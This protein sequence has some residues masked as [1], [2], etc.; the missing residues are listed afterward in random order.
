MRAEADSNTVD[1]VLDKSLDA[2]KNKTGD[3]VSATLSADM[4]SGNGLS[5]P[6]G[7]KL[8]GHITEAKPKAKGDPNSQLA[9]AFDKVVPKGGNEIPVHASIRGLWKPQPAMMESGGMP[10]GPGVQPGLGG[11]AGPTGGPAGPGA[12]GGASP[13]QGP[14]GRATTG[15]HQSENPSA[16]TAEQAARHGAP[17]GAVPIPGLSI[18]TKPGG[19]GE[20]TMI[21]STTRTVHLDSGTHLALQ[22]S[23]EKQ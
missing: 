19:Q 3:Q 21:T 5:I 2:K 9:I 7:S 12:P 16:E 18:D 14:G 13:A 20:G 15:V 4:K 23:T 17:G 22:L 6:K 1:A 10:A 8:V 11:P